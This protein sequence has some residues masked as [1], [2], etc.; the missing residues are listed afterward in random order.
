MVMY[1][2]IILVPSGVSHLSAL[3]IPIQALVSFLH[4]LVVVQCAVQLRKVQL[5][6]SVGKKCKL[7]L[8]HA[9]RVAS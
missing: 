6:S 1:S 2:L 3:F 7:E 4:L 9:R 8:I 5:S